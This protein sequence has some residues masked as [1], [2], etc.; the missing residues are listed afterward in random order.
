[1]SQGFF[2]LVLRVA[3]DYRNPISR[4]LTSCCKSILTSGA[5]DER[6]STV[7]CRFWAPVWRRFQGARIRVDTLSFV[8]RIVP[9]PYNG[10]LH[11]CSNRIVKIS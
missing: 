1:M 5:T 6:K 3:V 10:I 11:H 4:L 9:H 8:A 7:F 2:K